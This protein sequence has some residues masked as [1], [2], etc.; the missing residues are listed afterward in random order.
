MLAAAKPDMLATIHLLEARADVNI[1]DKRGR[2]AADVCPSADLRKALQTR[3][4]R[5]AVESRMQR[6]CSLPAISKSRSRQ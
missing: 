2:T 3:A 1:R 6:S 4:E 5:E